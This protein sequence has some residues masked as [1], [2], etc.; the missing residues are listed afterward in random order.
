M[1]KRLPCIQ[2]CAQLGELSRAGGE[3]MPWWEETDGQD[4]SEL[5]FLKKPKQII[6]P[7]RKQ[8]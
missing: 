2:N 4:S 1:C 8:D 7:C 6:K 3:E 5:S